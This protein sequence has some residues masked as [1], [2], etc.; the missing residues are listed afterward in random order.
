MSS[1]LRA[2]ASTASQTG[3]QLALKHVLFFA[4][5]GPLAAALAV[6]GLASA[7]DLPRMR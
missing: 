7:G 5:L 2:F 3:E 4:A 6:C 1:T